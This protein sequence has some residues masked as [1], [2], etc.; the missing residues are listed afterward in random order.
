ME[1]SKL[2]LISVFYF[3]FQ[4]VSVDRPTVG[5]RMNTGG[6]NS[7]YEDSG[8][9]YREGIGRDGT[10]IHKFSDDA[11]FQKVSEKINFS[12]NFRRPVSCHDRERFDDFGGF[13]RD[14]ESSRRNLWSKDQ[15]WNQFHVYKKYKLF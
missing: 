4:G 1:R 7:V 12:S 3:L 11:L 2:F 14:R 15:V 5:Q 9:I 8:P 10:P 6:P 13:D